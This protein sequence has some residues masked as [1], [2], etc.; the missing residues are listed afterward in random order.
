MAAYPNV[1]AA[2]KYARDIVAGK[3]PAARITQQAC[4]RHL[5]DLKRQKDKSY[6]YRFD[7]EKG[8]RVCKF[9]QLLVHTKGEW[10]GK[11]LYQRRIA[12]EP[13]Q[14]FAFSTIFGWVKKKN[15]LRRFREAYIEV[16]RKN[17]KSVVAA[18]IGLYCLVADKEP[19]AE[20]YC[21][22]GSE[23]Q[24]WKVFEPAQK[25]AKDLPNLRSRF[26]LSVWA[27]KLKLV[28]G[29][30]FEPVIGEP[31][32]GANPHLGIVDEFHEHATPALYDTLRTGM[33]ARLQPLMLAITTAGDNISS[34][35]HDMHMRVSEML[36]DMVEDDQLFGLIYTID[37]EDDW[38]SE[39]A[40][41]K[42]NPNYGVSVRKDE[43]QSLQQRAI[44]M[45][46]FA[47]T[48]KT[49]NLNLWVS[50]KESFFN[51][52]S[53]KNCEDIS[54]T[55]EQ[56]AGW[57]SFLAFDLAR[58][59]DLTAMVRLYVKE[60]DRKRHYYCV[61]PMFWVPE[62]TVWDTDNRKQADRYQ[63]WV[64][65]Q[66]NGYPVLTATEGAEVDYREILQAAIDANAH[67][68]SISCPI[69][70]H[71]AANLSHQMQDEGLQPISITQNYTHMSDPMKELEAAIESGRF[72]HDG[73]PLMTWCI[74][75]VI[76]KHISGD[77][78]VVRPIKQGNDNKIDG[79]VALI[80][81]IGRAMVGD[82]RKESIYDTSD[83]L[84]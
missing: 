24:A 68:P 29:S 50:A 2:N 16:P 51:L 20:V 13:W 17:G 38:T 25:I 19:G 14:K 74:S 61:A 39:E 21:G 33:G 57:D 80:M 81:A 40:L 79:A 83:V 10:A 28:D 56:F 44:K 36:E 63:K 65:M 47:N 49:K 34:P 43:I 4:Q 6:P 64:A 27:K 26:G 70:P 82:A 18:G 58:K 59:L 67:S 75:N 35:C 55:L 37:P 62:E 72:H 32:D 76:G 42:A 41:I 73:N 71:G 31:G 1:S 12:L 9:I 48:F 77:D 60:I 78:D 54:L 30:V 45:A 69:D 5:D 46:R 23:N 15:K 84:C 22:A 3:I 8:E 53:W 52:E 66:H 7:K 11:P